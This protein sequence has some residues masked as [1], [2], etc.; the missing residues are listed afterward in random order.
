MSAAFI[1]LP[2]RRLEISIVALI[3]LALI[4]ILWI[5]RTSESGTRMSI[6]AM[7]ILVPLQVGILTAGLL[8]DDPALELLLTAPRPTRHILADRLFIVLAFGVFSSLALQLLANRWGIFVTYEGIDQAFIWLS[9]LFFYAGASS[10]ASLI[11]GRMLDGVIIC[12]IVSVVALLSGPLITASCQGSQ[13]IAGCW[14]AVLNPL[15]T[16]STPY[17]PFWPANRVLWFILGALLVGTNLLLSGQGER[18]FHDT[19]VE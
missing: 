16:S 19:P 18:L 11:R 5:S 12:L 14:L 8:A 3:I 10:S 7:E 4:G 9:P 15:M 13:L 6:T 1:R 17:D 2:H